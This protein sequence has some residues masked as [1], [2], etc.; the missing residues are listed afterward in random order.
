MPCDKST[1]WLTLT[2]VD[3]VVEAGQES[4]VKSTAIL[5]EEEVILL[6]HSAPC[7]FRI[8]ICVYVLFLV[9]HSPDVRFP[10]CG[11]EPA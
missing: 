5:E 1:Q 2:G 3:E 10:K 8:W 6:S 11:V 9:Q 4:L 7:A